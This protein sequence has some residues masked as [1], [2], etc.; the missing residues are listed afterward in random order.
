MKKYDFKK[1][2]TKTEDNMYKKYQDKNVMDEIIKNE[3]LSNLI[4][5]HKK[6][7]QEIKE[8]QKNYFNSTSFQSEFTINDREEKNINDTND[9]KLKTNYET[10]RNKIKLSKNIPIKNYKNVIEPILDNYNTDADTNN[11][12]IIRNAS[13]LDESERKDLENDINIIDQKYLKTCSNFVKRLTLDKFRNL[14]NYSS[15]Y[16]KFSA[17]NSDLSNKISNNKSNINNINRYVKALEF[18]LEKK[19]LKINNLKSDIGLLNKENQYLKT[20]INEL[21]SKMANFKKK[22]MSQDNLFNM[23][24]D[25]LNKIN[26]LAKEISAKNAQIERMKSMDKI[27]VKDIKLLNQEYR[28][29]ELVSNE[30]KKKK[31]KK[32]DNLINEN[33]NFKAYINNTDKI[34][35]TINYFIKKIYNLVPSLGKYEN[36]KEISEPYE[37]QKHLIIIENFINEFIIYN[38]KKPQISTNFEKGKNKPFLTERDKNKNKIKELEKIIN[39]ITKQK[40][41]LIKEI[42]P[43]KKYNRKKLVNS[44]RGKREFSG[45]KK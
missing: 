18:K 21:E 41:A 38:N 36:F 32:I 3:L 27:K 44:Y 35:F 31:I 12:N 1:E 45:K 22:N 33:N 24:K 23:E 37:L 43:K 26:T 16:T 20:Y 14:N 8:W 29:L 9:S 34:L 5:Q 40:I 13:A 28:D 25:I 10:F 2:D 11:K 17:N 30:N 6:R 19:R 39:G 7:L 42:Q 15:I 4:K